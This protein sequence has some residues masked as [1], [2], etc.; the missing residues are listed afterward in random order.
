MF[1]RFIITLMGSLLMCLSMTQAQAST[2]QETI[3]KYC[4]KDCISAQ[5]L[6]EIS[7]KIARAYGIDQRAIIAIVHIESKYHIKA[8][9]GSSVGLSQ[10][11][12]RYHKGKFKG[13]NHFDPEDNLFAGM[14]VFSQCLKKTKGN[15]NKAYG[16]YNGGGDKKYRSK[17]IAAYDMIKSLQIPSYDKDPLYTFIMK[18]KVL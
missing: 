9:N 8:K 1:T 7:S 2:L 16:C 11:L 3:D 12:L 17:A 15:Y 6:S 5:Y 18:K 13:K 10:V 4:R 14:Q